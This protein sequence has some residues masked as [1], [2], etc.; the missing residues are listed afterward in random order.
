M[1]SNMKNRENITS[2]G[3]FLPWIFLVF[4]IFDNYGKIKFLT[5]IISVVVENSVETV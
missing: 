3:V 1:L 4:V 5:Y 2:N